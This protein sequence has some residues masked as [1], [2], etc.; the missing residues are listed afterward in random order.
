[1]QVAFLPVVYHVA[2]QCLSLSAFLTGGRRLVIG[3]RPV[4]RRWRPRC[5]AER[6]DVDLGGSRSW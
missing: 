5:T 1:M 6:A 3:R 2:D 4:R